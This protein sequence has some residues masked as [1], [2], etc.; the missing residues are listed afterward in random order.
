[1]ETIDEA[2]ATIDCSRVLEE[3][4]KG[5]SHK[6]KIIYYRSLKPKIKNMRPSERLKYFESLKE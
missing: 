1:M 6:E 4:T 2:M 3:L 5:M